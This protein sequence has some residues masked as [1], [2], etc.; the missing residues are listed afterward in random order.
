MTRKGPNSRR[1]EISIYIASCCSFFSLKD[2]MSK[3]NISPIN[4]LQICNGR[5]ERHQDFL[6]YEWLAKRGH[7]CCLAMDSECSLHLKPR[8]WDHELTRIPIQMQ[9]LRRG[10]YFLVMNNQLCFKF[11]NSI[12]LS[13][14]I[15][16]FVWEWAVWMA[17]SLSHNFFGKVWQ[18]THCV[19]NNLLHCCKKIKLWQCTQFLKNCGIP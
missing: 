19:V 3:I 12:V 17:R 8:G 14:M 18:A 6:D 1:Y 5:I 7:F 13:S 16:L 9:V 11:I 4:G 2:E 15:N 10:H